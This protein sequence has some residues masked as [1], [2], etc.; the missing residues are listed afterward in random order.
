MV[1]TRTQFSGEQAPC[2][3]VVAGEHYREE[4]DQGLVIYDQYY[5]CGC[6][7]IRHEYHDGSVRTT[8]TRHDRHKIKGGFDSDHGF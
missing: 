3:R 7:Q 8:A 6:R 1:G 2:G 4:D 5:D